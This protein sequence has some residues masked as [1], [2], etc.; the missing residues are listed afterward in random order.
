MKFIPYQELNVPN[1]IVD[2][3]PNE[4]TKLTLSH[5]PKSPTPAD[6]KDDLSAQIVF[7]YLDQPR[8]HLDVEAVSNNHFD[9]DG[10]VSLFTILNPERA[11]FWRELLIDIAAAG[12]FG[13]YRFPEADRIAFTIAAYADREKSPLPREIFQQ[14]YLETTAALYSELL[15]LLPEIISNPEKFRKMWKP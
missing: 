3:A 6:L 1:I 5:W 11:S 8:F 4:F 7:H 14:S 10:L 15:K 9:E 2:G 12:D 13:T